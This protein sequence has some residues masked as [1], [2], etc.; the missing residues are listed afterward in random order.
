MQKRLFNLMI[1]LTMLLA[2]IPSVAVAAPQG[3][4]ETV[5]TVQKDDSLWAIAEKYLGSGAAYGAVV[6][7]TN[8]KH[9]T[10]ASFAKIENPGVIQP[11][12]K[13]L[14]PSAEE[15]AKL[16]E[17]WAKAP[18]VGGEL[19][20]ALY[21]EP[22][23]IDP[24]RTGT[25]QA[26]VVTIQVCESLAIGKPDGTFV[27]GLAT[28][29][30]IAEDGTSYTFHLREGVKFH[31]GTPFNAQAVKYNFDR[32][33]D[34]ATQSERAIGN[35]GPYS[36]TEVVDDYTAVVHLKSPF[37]PFMD[38]V[39]GEFLCMVSPTAAAKWG[40]DEFQDHLVGTGPF[41]FKEWKRHEYM[42]LERNPDYWGGSEFFE[43]QGLAYLDAIVF[44]FISEASV[45]SGTLETGEIHIAQ[46]VPAVD[47]VRLDAK[48]DIDM[49]IKPA[50]GTGIRLLFNMSK[51]PTDDLRVRQAINY[52]V[53]QKAI[54]E[55]LYQGI[56]EP[57][58]G[59]LT[60]VALCYWSGAEEMYAYDPEKAKALL[61]EAG[62]VDTDGDGIRDK[63]GQP[64]RLDLPTHGGYFLYRDPCPIVQ[65]QL[66]EV[67]IDVNVM[68]LAAPAWLEAGRTG[69]QHIGIVDMKGSDPYFTLGLGYHSSQVTAF[70][71]NHHHNSHLDELLDE[72]VGVVDPKK[73]CAI[74]EEVQKIIMED[75]M[76]KPIHSYVATW[77]VRS[78]VK[79]LKFHP[80]PTL[81]WTFDMYFTK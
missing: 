19:V 77:G 4:E 8:A 66:G 6:V 24:H 60:P 22:S 30:E 17:E 25:T 13:V 62:W 33:V 12:W 69:N 59:A 36:S 48:P 37:A 73:R 1:A 79:G 23:K 71:W 27:P 49:L 7:A 16:A 43:H 29:W 35:L 68:N 72:A 15:A 9:E 38:G 52:A 54:S 61:E 18:A 64:L 45:R 57:I 70:A 26:T 39:A 50:P 5:Y 32:I 80:N 46:D 41:I 20:V 75:A 67:G 31:D 21:A 14:I 34:P 2:L 51:A 74:Y 55:I 3:Q 53:D 78:E 11:G 65:A 76:I 81:F 40:P 47:V 56:L 28:S 58:Y 42:R 63:D 10:D 44:K